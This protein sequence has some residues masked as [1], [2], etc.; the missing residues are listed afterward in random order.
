MERAEVVNKM[1]LTLDLLE[2]IEEPR[3]AEKK[4]EMILEGMTYSDAEILLEYYNSVIWFTQG[5]IKG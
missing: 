2:V 4:G 5:E 3:K 1:I